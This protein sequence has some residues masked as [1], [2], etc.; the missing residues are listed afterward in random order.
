MC[1][2]FRFCPN[3]RIPFQSY[4]SEFGCG[5]YVCKLTSTN[6][7]TPGGGEAALLSH[8]A[9]GCG[10]S[11]KWEQAQPVPESVVK[12]FFLG[13]RTWDHYFDMRGV[14][15]D[16][17]DHCSGLMARLQGG[18]K[19]TKE[20][21]VLD[22]KTGYAKLDTWEWGGPTSLEVLVKYDSF[23]TNGAN[24]LYFGQNNGHDGVYVCNNNYGG[25]ARISW[26]VYQGPNWK[27]LHKDSASFDLAWTHIV[28]TTNGSEMCVYKNGRLAGTSTDGWDPIALNRDH[29]CIGSV[30]GTDNFL[31]GTVAYLR[32]WHGHAL[33]LDEVQKLYTFCHSR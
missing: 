1:N 32:L 8:P 31:H 14:G 30:R 10:T 33:T 3:C 15:G 6:V 2:T 9:Y 16:V 17:T 26:G 7:F 4:R 20:G 18:A 22:G 24:V 28:V 23:D 21:L 11:F 29:H 25:N 19:R 12:A 13:V 27:D 5:N